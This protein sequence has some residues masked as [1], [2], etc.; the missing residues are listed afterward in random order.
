MP[1]GQPARRT[2]MHHAV[3]LVPMSKTPATNTR[4]VTVLP[5]RLAESDGSEYFRTECALTR[6]FLIRLAL[7]PWLEPGTCGLRLSCARNR[8]VSAGQLIRMRRP[9]IVSVTGPT[10][11]RRQASV[12]DSVR[13]K[14]D[15]LLLEQ[16]AGR[17]RFRLSTRPHHARYG[18]HPGNG[19]AVD[20]SIGR[21]TSWWTSVH[22]AGCPRSSRGSIDFSR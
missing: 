10:S 19:A 2:W 22:S 14:R 12:S 1:I 13:L 16:G 3:V 9:R 11:T 5:A 18:T 15:P 20:E 6:K 17:N 21:R 4:I 8:L 7:R